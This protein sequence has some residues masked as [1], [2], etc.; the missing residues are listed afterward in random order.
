VII[1]TGKR[2]NNIG[3]WRDGNKYSGCGRWKVSKCYNTQ[4]ASSRFEGRICTVHARHELVN[5][6]TADTSAHLARLITT[7][8]TI[9][10]Y[11][12]LGPG[13]RAVRLGGLPI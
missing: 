7:P 11:V 9:V 12:P 8:I 2:N 1:D 3:N 6:L 5:L 4:S 13:V 10:I